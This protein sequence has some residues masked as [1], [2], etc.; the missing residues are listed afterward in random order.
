MSST[1]VVSNPKKTSST[2]IPSSRSARYSFRSARR[3]EAGS[4]PKSLIRHSLVA[5]PI[6][7]WKILAAVCLSVVVGFRVMGSY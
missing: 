6:L 7:L 5:V 2:E 1:S 4:V 3:E